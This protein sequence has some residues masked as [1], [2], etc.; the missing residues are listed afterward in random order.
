MIKPFEAFIDLHGLFSKEDR[1]L[2]ACSGGID[3]VVLAHLLH[4]GG[5]QFG[6]AHVNYHLRG[7]ES[8][9][10]AAWVGQI[11]D[12]WDIPFHLLDCKAGAMEKTG[13]STQMAARR[14]R[15]E[16][17]ESIRRKK[18]YDFILT[19]H[20]ANDSIETFFLNFARG[21]GLKGLAGIPVRRDR[22]ARPLLFA[23]RVQIESFAHAHGI[24]WREDQ[25]NAE[26]KY[27]RN[28]IRHHI[29]PRLEELN[30]QFTMRATQSLKALQ[31]AGILVKE[32]V[33]HWATKCVNQT[34]NTTIIN[35]DPLREHEAKTTLLYHWVSPFGFGPDQ[36]QQAMDQT[37][38]AGAIFYAPAHELLVDRKAWLIR[39]STKN[40][41]SPHYVWPE[42]LPAIVIPGGRLRKQK[43]EA[44]PDL[45]D[46]TAYRVFLDS[47]QLTFPLT[48]RRWQEGD[49]FAPLGMGGKHQ[50][51]Q[52][53][54]THQKLNRWEKEKVWL[55][56]TAKGE[57]CW[58]VGHRIDHHFRIRP[59]TQSCWEFTFDQAVKS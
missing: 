2:L 43:M 22:I 55:L 6:I 10:D 21:T 26:D 28:K 31:E 15:Y 49:R 58:V 48:L 45:T 13:E 42:S 29:I 38:H 59:Q 24:V 25:S 5:W 54:F 47:E 52:D 4:D 16:W 11:A 40:S 3:S 30:P 36:L 18:G 51:I 9:T 20:H 41:P 17:L 1:L 46:A 33:Q 37:E 8:D 34:G 44:L 39:P 7:K 23:S 57:I 56:T 32:A 19:A 27:D 50:K 35:L 12:R 53:F 14:I